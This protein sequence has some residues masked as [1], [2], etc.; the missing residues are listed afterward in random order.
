MYTQLVKIAE[1]GLKGDTKAVEQYLKHFI[2]M[3]GTNNHSLNMPLDERLAK[4]FKLLLNN[5]KGG[6]VTMD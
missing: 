3:H 4:K 1:H 5:E 6:K 2:D